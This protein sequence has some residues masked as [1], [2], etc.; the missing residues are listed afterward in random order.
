[1]YI[2]AQCIHCKSNT[3]VP[4]DT[5]KDKISQY[6]IIYKPSHRGKHKLQININGKEIQD[7]PYAVA[8]TSSPQSFRQ[9]GRVIQNLSQPW[10]VTNNSHGQ[11]IVTESGKFCVNVFDSEKNKVLKFGKRGSEPGVGHFLFPA[12]V[13]VDSDDNIYVVDNNGNCIQKFSPQGEFIESVGEKGAD[14][15]QFYYPLGIR[16]HPF[17]HKL[18]VCDQENHR[19]QVLTTDLA[20]HNCFGSKGKGYGNFLK[21]VGVAF[22][23][24]GNI[25]ITDRFNGRVQVFREDGQFY[26]LLV[27]DCYCNLTVLILTQMNTFM[28]VKVKDIV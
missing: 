23:R 21:P 2:T 16:Y 17:N 8:V 12:G 20:Y 25:F 3:P 15:L 19:V 14:V 7:S 24:N 27:M 1:M 18:Y 9:Q 26:M 28:C 22:N 6:K 13:T 4:C 11:I 10:F 5:Q